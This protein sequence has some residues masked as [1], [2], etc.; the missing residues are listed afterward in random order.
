MKRGGFTLLEVLV[1]LV[2]F[3]TAAV[4]LAATYL[5]VLNAYH[6][7]NHVDP[8]GEDVRFARAQMMAEPDRTKAEDGGDFET[9]TG[10]ISW[11]AKIDTTNTAD[12]FQVTFT[13]DI[14]DSTAKQPV[15]PI[16]ETFF[17]LRPT[18]SEGVDSAKLREKSKERIVELRKKT[19]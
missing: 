5:N 17:L 9:S 13:C 6:F 1:A 19:T 4:V 18:W 10:R 2:V 12:V 11:K 15:R 3:T 8:Y 16:V 7:A 14:A